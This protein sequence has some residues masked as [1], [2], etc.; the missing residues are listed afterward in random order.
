VSG[1]REEIYRSTEHD[2]IPVEKPFGIDR[3]NLVVVGIRRGRIRIGR[4]VWSAGDHHLSL[5]VSRRD[6]RL[7]A[8]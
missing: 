1:M 2:P 7:K 8:A 4:S 6:A 5:A 3:K